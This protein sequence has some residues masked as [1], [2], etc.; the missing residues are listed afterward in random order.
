MTKN[1]I[2]TVLEAEAAA[3]KAIESAHRDAEA[4]RRAAHTDARAIIERN[5]ARTQRAIKQYEERCAAQLAMQIEALEK[6]AQI[7]ND[8]FV[9]LV[10]ER[11]DDIIEEAFVRLWPRP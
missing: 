5:E 9:N 8:K 1:P 6:E 3:K 7:A 11:M 2:Q 10:D 4:K